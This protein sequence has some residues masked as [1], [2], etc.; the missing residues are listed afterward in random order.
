[1]SSTQQSNSADSAEPTRTVE[2]VKADLDAARLSRESASGA[3][4]ANV[5]RAIKRLE[6]ELAAFTADQPKMRVAGLE[7]AIVVTLREQGLTEAGED[8]VRT[9]GD[10]IVAAGRVASYPAKWAE[11]G[12]W[13]STALVKRVNKALAAD[14]QGAA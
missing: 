2:D 9:A 14:E 13:V 1:M 4:K 6:A 12:Y 3:I 8:E 11:D 5:T 7:A 10:P